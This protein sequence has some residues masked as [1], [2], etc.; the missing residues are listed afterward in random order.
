[1]SVE[2]EPRLRGESRLS[3]CRDRRSDPT[4]CTGAC[5][6]RGARSRS[7]GDG[8]AGRSHD[9]HD[10]DRRQ[11]SMRHR[12]RGRRDPHDRRNPRP[13]F[14]SQTGRRLGRRTAPSVAFEVLH[15]ISEAPDPRPEHSCTNNPRRLSTLEPRSE[16][17]HRALCDEHRV[18]R[19]GS[20]TVR[21][22]VVIG[23][24]AIR[25]SVRVLDRLTHGP[26]SRERREPAMHADLD[27]RWPHVHHA[28]QICGGS[29]G[30]DGKLLGRPHR[31]H[32]RL[33]PVVGR[34]RDDVGISAPTH[35]PGICV[36]L[37]S[38]A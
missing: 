12:P 5:A 3:L 24:A 16:R 7:A 6:T 8:R 18:C 35:P 11:S 4:R 37:Q 10:G 25:R 28:P 20:T 2:G 9:R 32:H 36:V 14:E 17:R 26:G 15:S 13:R 23:S 33:F 1:M 31:R 29:V 19:T 22:G 21:A 38:P 30:S 27:D 34:T